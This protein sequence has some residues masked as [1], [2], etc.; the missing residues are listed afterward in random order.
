MALK[1]DIQNIV[2]KLLPP[3]TFFYGTED[4]F[5][6]FVDD[7]SNLTTN[8]VFYLYSTPSVSFQLT[9]S[10]AIS[11][12]T[13]VYIAMLYKIGFDEV[14]SSQADPYFNMSQSMLNQ[15]LVH[16]SNYRGINGAKVYNRNVGDK[17]KST[18]CYF[19]YADTNMC[20]YGFG[21]DLN[22]FANDKICF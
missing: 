5:N 8:G 18:K 21:L 7:A 11:N 19:N 12:D 14:N 16:L 15:F 3:P 1:D 9:V 10:P 6:T 2:S 4:E 22:T 17:T 20:G 13:S